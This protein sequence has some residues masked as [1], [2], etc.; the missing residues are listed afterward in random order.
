MEFSPT[1]S[2]IVIS[3]KFFSRGGGAFFS[4]DCFMGGKFSGGFFRGGFFPGGFFPGG[5]FPR[6]VKER[7]RYYFILFKKII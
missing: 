5:I 7:Y 4:G 2:L 3:R 1:I 6:T